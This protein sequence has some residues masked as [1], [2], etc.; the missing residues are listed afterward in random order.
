MVFEV[1]EDTESRQST[2]VIVE[3]TESTEGHT[4]IRCHA[5]KWFP[6]RILGIK[7]S[8][9]L[10]NLI[11]NFLLLLPL[12]NFKPLHL[13]LPLFFYYHFPLSPKPVAPP[14]QALFTYL[15]F[16]PTYCFINNLFSKCLLN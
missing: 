16:L 9:Q 6:S 10:T 13:F 7:L 2:E 12:P 15:S 14:E 11:F 5:Q 3:I 1:T 8:G 4:D